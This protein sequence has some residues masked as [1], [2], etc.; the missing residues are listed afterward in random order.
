MINSGAETADQSRRRLASDPYRPAYHF[1]A[2][3]NWLN[4]PNG[5]IF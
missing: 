5:T 2:S 1:L 3:C 4:D